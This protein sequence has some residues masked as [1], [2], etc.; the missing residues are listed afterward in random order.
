M[1]NS[2]VDVSFDVQTHA[3]AKFFCHELIELI[4]KK[5]PLPKRVLVAGCGAGH[6]AA[7]ISEFFDAEVDAI[8]VDHAPDPK[9][10]S[11][12]KLRFQQASVESTSFEDNVFDAVFYHHV[13]EHVGNPAA[14]LRELARVLRPNGWM[15]IGT[16]NRHRLVSAAGAHKQRDWSPSFKSKFRENWQ[17]WTA[18]LSGRFKNEL[19]AHAGFSTRELDGLLT[20]H[21]SVRRWVTKQYLR[22]KYAEHRFEEVVRVATTPALQ[23]C[24][25]PSIYAFCRKT[26]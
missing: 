2:T 21:F 19:G 4:G 24:L 14:S 23:W 22:S 16:P 11:M 8:D 1:S 3:A 18:R 6:E 17:D 13:I 10:V 7:Y 9:F 12:P 20:E 26:R 5:Y 25:A 15:F